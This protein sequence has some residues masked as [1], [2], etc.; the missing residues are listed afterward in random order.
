MVLTV[1]TKSMISHDMASRTNRNAVFDKS[2]IIFAR[3]LPFV[4]RIE[5]DEGSHII[6]M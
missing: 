6:M 3:T 2:K 1:F 4:S 5:V